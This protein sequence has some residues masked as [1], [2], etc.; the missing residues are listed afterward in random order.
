MAM[1]GSV[2]KPVWSRMGRPRTIPASQRAGGLPYGT[3][4][5]TP[6]PS[7]GV[8]GGQIGSDSIEA[9]SPASFFSA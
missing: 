9:A 2:G 4:E 6:E 1:N 8:S 5:A 3:A 7:T